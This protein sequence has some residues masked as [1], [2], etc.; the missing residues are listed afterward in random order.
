MFVGKVAVKFY[1]VKVSQNVKYKGVLKEDGRFCSGTWA[2]SAQHTTALENR[3]H[4]RRNFR[5][6]TCI[7]FIF[8]LCRGEWYGGHALSP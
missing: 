5:F 6:E 3:S 4:M 8:M 7:R 1:F 2:D